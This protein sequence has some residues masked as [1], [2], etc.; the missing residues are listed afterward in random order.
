MLEVRHTPLHT[1]VVHHAAGLWCL[2]R[3][4]LDGPRNLPNPPA[5]RQVREGAHL[6][7][8]QVIE[9]VEDGGSRLVDSAQDGVAF[10]R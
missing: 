2:H 3:F 4:Q 1:A 7:D 5:D 8:E 10:E 9:Q 6:H